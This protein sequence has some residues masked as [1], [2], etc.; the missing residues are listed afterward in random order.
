MCFAY[1]LKGIVILC[2]LEYAF[3][4]L[5]L[6]LYRCSRWP[7]KI[8]ICC[9][10]GGGDLLRQL[11]HLAE[12]E[13]ELY[14]HQKMLCEIE[15]KVNLEQPIIFVRIKVSCDYQGNFF[16]RTLLT[17]CVT[18]RSLHWLLIGGIWVLQFLFDM[19]KDLKLCGPYECIH[20]LDVW[21]V[22]PWQMH[23]ACSK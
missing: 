18:F 4:Y 19:T 16:M 6:L 8:T 20:I 15:A 22:Y 17:M 5:C 11:H 21:Y 14:A 10:R 23:F 13:S 2:L 12:A 7:L 3:K 9:F 1:E